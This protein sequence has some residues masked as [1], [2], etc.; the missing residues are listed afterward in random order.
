MW[1]LHFIM[2]PHLNSPKGSLTLVGSGEM[3][4][5]MS[6]VHRWVMSQL[7]PPVRA[8]FLDT[9]AG[10]QL[11]VDQIS[12]KAARYFQKHFDTPLS[13]AS[14]KTS[15]AAPADENKALGRIRSAGYLFAGPGSPTYTVLNWENTRIIKALRSRL[16]DGA[17][18]VFASAASIA[19]G[20]FALPVYEIYKVGASPYWIN[21]LNFL[22]PMGFEPVFIPHWNNK[23]GGTHDT[24]YCYMGA[25]RFEKLEDLLP[26]ATVIL[27]IDEYT[28]V[29]INFSKGMCRVMGA[30]SAT[31]RKS[32][33]EIYFP[34]GKSFDIDYL[35]NPGGASPG[36]DRTGIADSSVET[37]PDDDIAR[38]E[39]DE[40]N[41]ELPADVI[42]RLIKI[43]SRLRNEQK[44]DLADD[45]RDILS[46]FDIIIEDGPNGS[47]W[48]KIG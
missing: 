2:H 38:P 22:R 10:F 14:F 7:S 48:K 47:T 5:P 11:N 18:L 35:K 37:I 46:S 28:A 16:I 30:G 44:W 24:R 34:A 27:G 4:L 23:E 43:R 32:G 21:G 25:P 19:V 42:R 36:E 9:P 31:L 17:H 39:E 41:A 6:K 12:E 8:V 1:Y 3:S 40:D 13:I 26:A 20:S 33:H 15:G 45:I 29:N